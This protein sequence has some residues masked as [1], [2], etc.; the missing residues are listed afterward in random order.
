MPAGIPISVPGMPRSASTSVTS[1]AVGFP[2]ISGFP[3]PSRWYGKPTFPTRQSE[4]SLSELLAQA[5]GV[6]ERGLPDAVWVRAE[7]TSPPCDGSKGIVARREE[8]RLAGYIKYTPE[9]RESDRAAVLSL[10]AERGPI[11]RSDI[12]QALHGQVSVSHVDQ[13]LRFLLQEGRIRSTKV[14]LTK[15][16]RGPWP[17]GKVVTYTATVYSVV[18][19]D[20]GLEPR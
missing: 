13:C 18:Q 3:A 14:T 9:Q 19:D 10:V 2:R 5:M 7:I 6:I 12:W 16:V 20:G 17:P 1:I 4:G 11:P 15:P 8:L